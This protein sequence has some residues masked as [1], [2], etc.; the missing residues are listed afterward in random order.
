MWRITEDWLGFQARR[1]AWSYKSPL[2]A[3]A[4]AENSS[5][6]AH[7]HRVQIDSRSIL[8][9]NIVAIQLAFPGV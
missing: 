6:S 8:Y 2:F 9:F 5:M 7:P 3:L 1:S 4:D